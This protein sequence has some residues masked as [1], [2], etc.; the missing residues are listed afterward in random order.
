M[1]LIRDVTGLRGAEPRS[2][3]LS[4]EALQRR[5]PLERHQRE[6]KHQR[7]KHSLQ[8]AAR[9]LLE[10]QTSEVHQGQCKD[11]R[12]KKRPA[13]HCCPAGHMR[14]EYELAQQPADGAGNEERRLQV[15]RRI[16]KKL[17]LL[18]RCDEGRQHD[19]PEVLADVVRMALGPP[20]ALAGEPRECGDALG[21]RF[22]PRRVRHLVAARV[23]LQ[24]QLPV[25]GE[26]GAPSDLAQQVGADHVGGTG[27]HLQRPDRVLERPL[28]HVAAGVLG[29][30]RLREPALL[31]VQNMPLVALNRGDLF[32][33]NRALP[34]LI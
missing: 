13:Q 31:L 22:R 15:V 9:S 24:R 3:V 11:V 14:L 21:G 17:K 12:E 26:A 20:H 6:G 34:L 19:R 23:K 10:D 30:H 18:Q 5:P 32:T 25:L 33:P 7:T 8:V 16:E 27:H 28:D 29:A 2:L 1:N 4:N